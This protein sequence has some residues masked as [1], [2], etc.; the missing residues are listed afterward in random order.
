MVS[1][2]LFFPPKRTRAPSRGPP[3]G[4]PSSRTLPSPSSFKTHHFFLYVDASPGVCGHKKGGSGGELQAGL[5][6]RPPPLSLASTPPFLAVSSAA[7]AFSPDPTNLRL[8]DGWGR[9][10]GGCSK[11]SV[12]TCS[13][14]ALP[15]PARRLPKLYIPTLSLLYP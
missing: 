4:A 10:S 2:I 15:G 6:S 3:H 7:A 13:R 11:N 14:S 1:E 12:R 5:C 9:G 8:A